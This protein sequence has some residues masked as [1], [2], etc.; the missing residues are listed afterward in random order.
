MDAANDAGK[1]MKQR[2]KVE[3]EQNIGDEIG[4]SKKL[5]LDSF[6]YISFASLA[7][8]D[9]C[10]QVN[11]DRGRK[12]EEGKKEI[13]RRRESSSSKAVRRMGGGGDKEGA[14][15]E[16]GRGRKARLLVRVGLASPLLPKPAGADSE[17]R[18]RAM[19]PDETS[20]RWR[21]LSFDERSAASLSATGRG[22]ATTGLGRHGQCGGGFRQLQAA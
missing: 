17:Q 8:I 13:E 2:H 19:W 7:Q 4:M 22:A 12:E 18:Q 6:Q 20:T 5:A 1:T 11:R 16:F 21:I 9:L 14:L 15:G 10:L 3:R